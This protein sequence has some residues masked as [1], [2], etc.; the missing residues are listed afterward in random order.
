[1]GTS[2]AIRRQGTAPTLHRRPQMLIAFALLAVLGGAAQAGAQSVPA[3]PPVQ[4]TV[5]E[6]QSAKVPPTFEYAARVVAS[7]EV[8]VRAQVGGILLKR[9]FVEGAEVQQG[10][11]L[12]E[13]DPRPY[14]AQLARARAQLQQA[15]AQL[16]QASRDFDR[17]ARLFETGTGTEKARDDAQSAKELAAAAVAAAEAELE[18]AE[19]NV[20]Y[21]KVT[22]PISGV[23]SLEQVPEG[24]L[25]GTG[26]A[27]LLTRITQLDPAHIIFSVT[28][29]EFAQARA[30]LEA[31]G[32]WGNPEDIV[33]VAIM[34]GDGRIYDHVGR[35]DFAA[36]GLD[37]ETG[38]LLMRAVVANPERRLLPGQFVRAIVKGISVND[39]IV[40]PYEAVMQSP[41]G[42]FVYTVD[43]ADNAQVRPVTLGREVETGWIVTSGLQSGDRLITEGIVKVRPGAP[44]S[45]EPPAAADA[46]S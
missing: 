17:A 21:T 9:N 7:R 34:F 40:V 8:E 46:G 38:T 36:S 11:V 16:A 14:A 27:G 18:S 25:I 5:I 13:I 15:Q 1:M 33:S 45:P 20:G 44:V 41:Q 43:E 2:W 37:L 24:S 23:T 4:V 42:Q 32:Q 6:V 29:S 12:F 19:L 3:A 26:D 31:Q 30:L 28:E 39:A 10:D 22:A 35:I